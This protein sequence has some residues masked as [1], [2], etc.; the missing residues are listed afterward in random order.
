MAQGRYVKSKFWR[1]TYTGT[2]DPSEKL[3]FLYLITNSETNLCGIYE[4]PLRLI[5]SDTGFDQEMI[6][7]FFDRFARDKKA[8]YVKGWVVIMN[9]IKHQ[10]IENRNIAAGIQREFAEIPKEVINNMN[11]RGIAYPYLIDGRLHLT[12]LNLT[13]LNL[14]DGRENDEESPK[15]SKMT[16]EEKNERFEEFWKVYPKKVGK[17]AAM[18]WWHRHEITEDTL[19]KM[20]ESVLK[21]KNTRGWKGGF[22]PNPLTFLHQGRYE[23][24]IDTTQEK[25]EFKT[26]AK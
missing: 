8:Y 9:A 5:A 25:K 24:E 7:K 4:L 11:E 2:L 18:K 20:I 23:D 14:T 6:L 22:I 12:I 13:I 19:K 26:Y 1:D 16:T 21:Y 3:L 17:V 10:A 15:S